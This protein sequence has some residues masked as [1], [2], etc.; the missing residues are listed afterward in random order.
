MDTGK[1][2][3]KMRA[4]NWMNIN[5]VL[6]QNKAVVELRNHTNWKKLKLGQPRG[7]R[8]HAQS[9]DGQDDKGQRQ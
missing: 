1:R 2:R 3:R 8:N 5:R 4:Q 6:A 9:R 7:E